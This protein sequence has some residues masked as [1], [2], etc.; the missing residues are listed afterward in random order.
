M[1]FRRVNKWR[2]VLAA[3]PTLALGLL[4]VPGQALPQND[5]GPFFPLRVSHAGQAYSDALP[6]GAS[7]SIVAGQLPLGLSLSSGG[8]VSGTPLETGTFEVLLAAIENGGARYP[9]RIAI[10]VYEQDEADFPSIAPS[11]ASAGPY[12]TDVDSIRVDV[13]NTFDGAVIRTRVRIVRPVGLSGP[14]P[15]LLFHRGRG[16]D[17]DD[18]TRL[19][20][21][22][23]SH[24]IAIAS[25][26]DDYS[27]SGSTFSALNTQYDL[28]RADLGMLSASG[29][30]EAVSDYLLDRSGD[31]GDSLHGS[32]DSEKLFFAGHSRGG[33]AVHAS[34]QRPPCSNSEAS[35]PRKPLT[36][37]VTF[38]HFDGNSTGRKRAISPA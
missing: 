17:E 15:L 36:R 9:V 2:L 16:F 13:V 5:P 22:I 25:V 10:T 27:F 12:G 1:V 28:W 14:A 34:H 3:L 18:Y 19:H 24:G 29:V 38:S 30:V 21:H 11:F 37:A 6:S 7:Y 31:P 23:A 8:R 33:G 20:A 32:F 4:A 26:E 35:A